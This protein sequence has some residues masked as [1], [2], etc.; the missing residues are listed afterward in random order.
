VT[1]S[2]QHFG[3]LIFMGRIICTNGSFCHLVWK[4][5]LQIFKRWWIKCWQDLVLPSAT[6]MTLSYLTWHHGIT[7]IIYKRYSEDLGII[8]L[9]FIHASAG[10]SKHRCNT[11]V[12]WFIHVDWGYK[13]PRLRPFHRYPNQQ[14]LIDYEPSHACVINIKDLLKD[15]AT[16]LKF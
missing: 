9:S 1:R 16:L 6:L 11:W 12:T 8:T 15:L 7:C 13:R 4:I 14:M 10:F 2:R 3:E 5:P